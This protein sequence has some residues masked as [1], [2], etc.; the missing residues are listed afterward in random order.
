MIFLSVSSLILLSFCCLT[1]SLLLSSRQCQCQSTNTEDSEL[2]NLSSSCML[3]ST[4]TIPHT[5]PH[6]LI[7]QRDRFCFG[8]GCF[9]FCFSSCFVLSLIL[10]TRQ[11][12][13]LLGGILT[14]SSYPDAKTWVSLS[15]QKKSKVLHNL[16]KR[17]VTAVYG[18]RMES[19]DASL[20]TYLSRQ[21]RNLQT[22]K[23]IVIYWSND[24]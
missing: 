24:G 12:C 7:S 14:R 4:A 8:L 1:P 9:C 10:C 5:K 20:A 6:A 3:R 21:L 17:L 23:G 19:Y 11:T 13:S 18:P 15:S 2:H 22:S 16:R